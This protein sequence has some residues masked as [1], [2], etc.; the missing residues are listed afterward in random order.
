MQFDVQF[1]QVNRLPNKLI[2]SECLSMVILFW[3][4]AYMN[5][6]S[7]LKLNKNQITCCS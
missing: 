1:G 4:S 7:V 6:R 5:I 3:F 2:F